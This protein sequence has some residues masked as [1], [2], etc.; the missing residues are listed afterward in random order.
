MNF[1]KITKIANNSICKINITYENKILKG[2]AFFIKFKVENEMLC[3]LITD[4]HVLKR[5]YLISKSIIEIYFEEKGK[6]CIKSQDMNFI[7]TDELIDITFIQLNDELIKNINPYFLT[8]GNK[9]C[10]DKEN[11]FIIHYPIIYKSKNNIKNTTDKKN[12]QELSIS[13]GNV[14]YLS[15]FNIFSVYSTCSASSGAP[16]IDKS[17]NVIGIH[18]SNNKIENIRIATNIFTAKYAI[19]TTYMRKIKNQ[20]NNTMYVKDLSKD[21]IDT[22]KKNNLKKLN[23]KLFKCSGDSVSLYFYRTN[24]AWYWTN[25]NIKNFKIKY[26]KNLNWTIITPHENTKNESLISNQ[27]QNQIIEWLKLSKFKY[28]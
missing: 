18:K 9:K 1:K 3:G 28:L 10:T 15:D 11:I 20:I 6:F 24:H 25:Q 19:C 5:K 21:D 7:F 27:N 2:T 8:L 26:L 12:S 17:L 22:I 23:N 16:I 14:E 13:I 4:N